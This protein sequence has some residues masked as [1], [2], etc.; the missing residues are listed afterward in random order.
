MTRYRVCQAF[1]KAEG[2]NVPGAIPTTHHN[3]LDLR[4][5]PGMTHEPGEAD[6]IGSEPTDEEG[7]LVAD[8]QV[9]L[10]AERGLSLGRAIDTQ[11]G[12]VR[13]AGGAVVSNVDNNNVETYQR[14]VLSFFDSSITLN[15][16]M[17]DVLK[18]PALTGT[19]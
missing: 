1:A 8:R 3:P 12:I 5:A 19:P 13:D 11:L 18:V 9:T 7:W 14:V 6:S 10:W 17:N 2:W 16:P 15:T 4:H